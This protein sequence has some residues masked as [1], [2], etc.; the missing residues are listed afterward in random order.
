MATLLIPPLT[1]IH[2]PPSIGLRV[3]PSFL[4]FHREVYRVW[5]SVV[6][7]SAFRFRGLFRRA[8]LTVIWGLGA[9][10][11]LGFRVLGFRVQGFRV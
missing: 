1:T 10:G 9:L 6:Q 4:G 2:E 7:L 8:P 3:F 5:F 11:F